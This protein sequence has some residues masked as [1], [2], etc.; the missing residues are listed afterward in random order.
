MQSVKTEGRRRRL[1]LRRH[2]LR[3]L[4]GSSGQ[5][6][7]R[8]DV[9]RP[10]QAAGRDVAARLPKRHSEMEKTK[11]FSRHLYCLEFQQEL[12]GAGR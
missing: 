8:P 4:R 6:L 12:S 10:S 11:H 9:G 2:N 5:R 1:H 7:A 3:R